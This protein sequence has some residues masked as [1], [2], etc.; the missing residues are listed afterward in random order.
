MRVRMGCRGPVHVLAVFFF[1]A[2]FASPAQC[3]R[4]LLEVGSGAGDNATAAVTNSTASDG[5]KVELIFCIDRSCPP[6]G[7]ICYCCG[8]IKPYYCY[9]TRSE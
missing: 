8:T 3:H 2:L 5:D 9:D 4:W 1:I 6:D 7:R